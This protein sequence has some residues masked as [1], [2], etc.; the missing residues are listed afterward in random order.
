MKCYMYDLICDIIS[1]CD[2]SCDTDKINASD[3]IMLEHQKKRENVE[4]I[5]LRK[6]PSK[7][8]LDMEFT[9]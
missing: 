5:F 1:C 8:C 7:R 2:R 6:S 9:A 4:I 3:K